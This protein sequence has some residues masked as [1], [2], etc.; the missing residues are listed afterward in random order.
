MNLCA[1]APATAVTP[2]RCISLRLPVFLINS[3]W[4]CKQMEQFSHQTCHVSDSPCAPPA[5]VHKSQFGPPHPQGYCRL[6]KPIQVF[7]NVLFVFFSP[8]KPDGKSDVIAHSTSS[9]RL[10]DSHAGPEPREFHS[11]SSHSGFPCHSISGRLRWR[12]S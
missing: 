4:N 2:G 9:I 10:H 7:L 11:C 8:W 3:K 6:S 12:S 1:L 5:K